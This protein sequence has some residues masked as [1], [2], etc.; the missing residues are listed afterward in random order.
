MVH[1][2]IVDEIFDSKLL[3]SISS[4]FS[5][6]A[7]DDNICITGQQYNFCTFKGYGLRIAREFIEFLYVSFQDIS[8]TLQLAESET[9]PEKCIDTLCAW[10]SVEHRLEDAGAP[11]N[12]TGDG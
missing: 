5:Q 2:R 3:M 11:A 12:Q 8:L 1:E 10:T 6:C 7:G 9:P 4:S